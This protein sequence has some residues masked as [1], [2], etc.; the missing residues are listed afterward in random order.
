[1]RGFWGMSEGFFQG[2]FPGMIIFHRGKHPEGL[3]VVQA[4]ILTQVY[5]SLFEYVYWL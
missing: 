4:R 1:M 2:N 5:K 3:S